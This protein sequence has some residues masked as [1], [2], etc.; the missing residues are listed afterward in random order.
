MRRLESYLEANLVRTKV[1]NRQHSSLSKI[2]QGLTC[3]AVGILNI[4]LAALTPD[5]YEVGLFLGLQFVCFGIVSL[6]SAF[7][8]EIYDEQRN[9]AIKIWWVMQ[10]PLILAVTFAFVAIH[11]AFGFYG[12]V[13]LGP[14]PAFIALAALIH[15]KYKAHDG[16]TTN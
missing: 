11:N 6:L 16:E 13:V 9:V 15:R 1:R 2:R 5:T 3:A 4:L 8:L 12:V 14:I 10:I 7:A